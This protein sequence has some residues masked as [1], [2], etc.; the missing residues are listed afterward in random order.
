MKQ[1]ITSMSE[2][3]GMEDCKPSYTPMETHLVLSPCSG[4]NGDDVLSEEKIREYQSRAGSCMHM[5]V[6]TRSDVEYATKACSRFLKSPGMK[7]MVAVDRIVRY[8]VTTADKCV[9]FDC[10]SPLV[11]S[12]SSYVDSNWASAWDAKSTSSG[13]VMGNGAGLV[14]FVRTQ[15]LPA[16]SSCEA[17]LI[18]VDDTARE[19]IFLINLMKEFKKKIKKPMALMEDNQSTIALCYNRVQQQR[20]KHI[21]V[22]Y[23]YI[24]H[25]IQTGLV[26]VL[27]VPSDCNAADCGTKPLGEALFSKHTDVIFGKAK[28]DVRGVKSLRKGAKRLK[29]AS[30]T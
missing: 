3:W 16:H 29:N 13:V 28:A 25:V 19:I 10:N 14:H 18:A 9:I 1:A 7:H 2:K 24:R 4:V 17:E 8:L 6:H 21:D 5:C 30:G 27:Y 23:F 12:I 26:K 22:R 11:E 15:R 20:S